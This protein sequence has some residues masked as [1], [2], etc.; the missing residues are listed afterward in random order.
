VAVTQ[1][2]KNQIA[3][4]LDLGVG[5]EQFRGNVERGAGTPSEKRAILNE[6]VQQNNARV[7]AETA[8]RAEEAEAVRVAAAA[9][10]AVAPAGATFN[11]ESFLAPVR[12]QLR[13]AQE[14]RA[15]EVAALQAELTTLR[16]ELANTLVDLESEVQSGRDVAADHER[17]IVQA[18]MDFAAAQLA[19][20]ERKARIAGLSSDIRGRLGGEILASPI[21]G[22]FGTAGI[23]VGPAVAGLSR[24]E[25]LGQPGSLFSAIGLRPPSAQALSRLT[26]IELDELV[27]VGTLAGLS[28]KSIRDEFSRAV[29]GGAQRSKT[30]FGKSTRAASLF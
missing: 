28:D 26:P 20:E 2:D 22:L 30:P 3:A 4:A 5:I 9:P 17:A 24:G 7:M 12:A 15:R 21:G 19:E 14:Q 6:F 11:V 23:E 25:I 8:A 1:G 29:P 16:G 27:S 10:A 13:V 18:E